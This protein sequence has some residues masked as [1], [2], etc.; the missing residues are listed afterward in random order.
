MNDTQLHAVVVYV[1]DL[2]GGG[3]GLRIDEQYVGGLH[4]LVPAVAY[5]RRIERHCLMNP[6]DD[7]ELQ[8]EIGR[9]VLAPWMGRSVSERPDPTANTSTKQPSTGGTGTAAERSLRDGGSPLVSASFLIRQPSHAIRP[10][11]VAVRTPVVRRQS[12]VCPISSAGLQIP[13]HGTLAPDPLTALAFALA[14]TNE[15][16]TDF[17][18][19]GFELLTTD[20]SGPFRIAAWFPLLFAAEENQCFRERNTGRGR[21]RVYAIRVQ[22]QNESADTIRVSL[23]E[24]DLTALSPH[25]IHYGTERLARAKFERGSLS[26]AECGQLGLHIL[27]RLAIRCTSDRSGPQR[28]FSSRPLLS[29]KVLFVYPSGEQTIGRIKIAQPTQR[30]SRFSCIIEA[31]ALPDAANEVCAADPLTALR[32]AAASVRRAVVRHLSIGGQVLAADTSRETSLDH[33]FPIVGAL[34]SD[35]GN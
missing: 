29:S 16:L 26:D 32:M 6:E 17:V 1:A 21:P 30:A 13:E 4:R 28:A 31:D 27:I 11:S 24:G 9:A 2:A 35:V 22:L 3:S 34:G 5:E 18:A 14:H 10:G 8:I 7:D 33:W 19:R 12:F 25:W 20:G 15:A 23:D